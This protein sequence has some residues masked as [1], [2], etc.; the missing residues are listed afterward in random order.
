M[1]CLESKS[2]Q[3]IRNSL[4]VM[5]RLLPQY[6]KVAHLSMALEKRVTNL[7]EEEK[8]KRQDLFALAVGLVK[9]EGGREGRG[10]EGRGISV[11]C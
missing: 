4:I 8:D 3:Q 9:R 5:T 1:T 2:Y 10:E 7:H 6:P 11:M